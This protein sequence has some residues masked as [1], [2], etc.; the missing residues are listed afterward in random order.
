MEKVR[1]QY[2]DSDDEPKKKV[3]KKAAK[4]RDDDE[5]DDVPAVRTKK[6]RPGVRIPEPEELEEEPDNEPEPEPEAEG[7]DD[8]LDDMDRAELK[9]FIHDN[10]LGEVVKVY[11]STTDDQIREK[12]REALGLN[13]G[14]EEEEEAPEPEPEEEDEAPEPSSAARSLASIRA[15]LGKK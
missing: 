1:A 15:K 2:S 6:N 11:K 10:D 9:A 3:T 5:E 14:D 8:G 13:G 4:R 7:S 12:I